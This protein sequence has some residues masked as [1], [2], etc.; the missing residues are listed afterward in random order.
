[1]KFANGLLV[2]SAGSQT[3]CA[4][5][6]VR[7]TKQGVPEVICWHRASVLAKDSI[8]LY[9]VLEI[10]V[11]NKGRK[12]REGNCQRYFQEFS[13]RLRAATCRHKVKHQLDPVSLSSSNPK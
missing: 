3:L 4:G 11:C 6:F 1:M 8:E 7:G 2:C 9:S 12:P 5:I 10:S 13:L